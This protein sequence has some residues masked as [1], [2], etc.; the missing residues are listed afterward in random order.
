MGARHGGRWLALVGEQR[1]QGHKVGALLLRPEH[2]EHAR[3]A[4]GLHIGLHFR[5]GD[6]NERVEP[7]DAAQ[8]RKQQEHPV[9]AAPVVRQLMQHGVAGGLG[10]ACKAARQHYERRAA[11]SE[12]QRRDAHIR[13]RKPDAP[14]RPDCCAAGAE[15]PLQGR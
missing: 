7:I 9:V 12:Q 14:P 2:P 4:G 15:L 8:S 1:E 10:V 5:K 13:Y 3:V 6:V 11:A